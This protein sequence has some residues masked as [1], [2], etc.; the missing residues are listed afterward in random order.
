MHS[1]SY[2]YQG[3]L[4]EWYFTTYDGDRYAIPLYDEHD[5]YKFMNGANWRNPDGFS[6]VGDNHPVTQVS[7]KDA[8]AYCEWAGKKLPTEAQWEKAARGNNGNKYPWGN[9]EPDP[10]KANY[11]L[12]DEHV[13]TTT[14]VDSSSCLVRWTSKFKANSVMLSA[15]SSVSD[16]NQAISA[17]SWTAATSKNSCTNTYA[18]ARTFPLHLSRVCCMAP[19]H[20]SST[21]P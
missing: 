11:R 2:S 10:T 13:G 20:Y 4:L 19:Y 3:N 7:Y 17:R 21:A 1:T 16:D 8:S 14:P 15:S 6:P 18:T 9:A 5:G 12:S